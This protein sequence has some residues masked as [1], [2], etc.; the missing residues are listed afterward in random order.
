MHPWTTPPTSWPTPLQPANPS[1]TWPPQST[2]M[3]STP[4]PPMTWPTTAPPP[5]STPQP[6]FTIEPQQ[7]V[8]NSPHSS[9]TTPTPV[10]HLDNLRI[11]SYVAFFDLAP[12]DS[13]HYA[14]T[15][16]RF[17]CNSPSC[18]TSSTPWTC[19]NFTFEP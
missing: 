8:I 15:V 17:P 4:R 16:I 12:T 11:T 6:A 9:G 18:S 5:T 7:F 1:S 3:A 19:Y 13:F 14:A 2:S 10:E